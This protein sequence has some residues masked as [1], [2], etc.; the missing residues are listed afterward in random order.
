MSLNLSVGNVVSSPAFNFI[1]TSELD[2]FSEFFKTISSK[3]SLLLFFKEDENK[4]SK[5]GFLLASATSGSG[6]TN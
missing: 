4:E 5:S 1:F 6:G 3:F 2:K